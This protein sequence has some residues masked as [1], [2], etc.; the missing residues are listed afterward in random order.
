[1]CAEHAFD[2]PADYSTVIEF[3]LWEVRIRIS[4][5]KGMKTIKMHYMLH[6]VLLI[7]KARVNKSGHLKY[8]LTFLLNKICLQYEA[9]GEKMKY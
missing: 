7:P 5:N 4:P 2:L 6:V 9:L 8:I 3:Y 1:M